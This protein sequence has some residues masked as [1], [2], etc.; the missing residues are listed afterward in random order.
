MSLVT[1]AYPAGFSPAIVQPARYLQATG[2][3]VDRRAD[4]Q[5]VLDLGGLVQLGPGVFWIGDQLEMRS[6]TTL[7]MDQSTTI[8]RIA[9]SPAAIMMLHLNKLH[10]VTIRGGCVDG[11]GGPEANG[12]DGNDERANC[13]GL[14]GGNNILIENVRVQNAPTSP[15]GGSY[16]DGLYFGS[17]GFN[18]ITNLLVI[19]LRSSSNGRH[20]S[21]FVAMTD[22]AFINCVWDNE[23]FFG[24]GEG[25]AIN[26]ESAYTEQ[27]FERLSF[28]GCQFS[29]TR[30]GITAVNH[31]GGRRQDI[32]FTACKF[33][34]NDLDGISAS[35]AQLSHGGGWTFR[36]CY[37]TEN[38][39][40]G[41]SLYQMVGVK[42]QGCTIR[43]NVSVGIGLGDCPDALVDGCLI[44][45]N[46]GDGINV[47][48]ATSE[49]DT[50]IIG[51]TVL[52]NGGGENSH[53][54]IA[55]SSEVISGGCR[56]T[57]ALCRIGNVTRYGDA[58]QEYGVF[59]RGVGA[60]GATLFGN[61]IFD[62]TVAD[63]YEWQVGD[64]GTLR[65]VSLL[66]TQYDGQRA[67]VLTRARAVAG[68][69]LTSTPGNVST[70]LCAGR[71]AIAAGA[72]S[73]TISLPFA[74]TAD[75]VHVTLRDADTTLTRIRAKVTADG[76][77]T[78]A[79]NATAT[80][81]VTFAWELV[82]H[83]AFNG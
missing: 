76:T 44:V 77:I 59:F 43:E 68:E 72:S 10:N 61:D 64:D 32:T 2:T 35:G 36:D 53:G 30:Y 17:D 19:G 38:G 28:Y 40:L 83:G 74:K 55:Q 25:G 79:G 4:L 75:D 21:Q 20:G 7:L 18:P 47:S 37:F 33:I 71:A 31:Y 24:L 3:T 27:V 26:L 56:L 12:F 34:N 60:R 65:S 51:C 67:A 29:N 8:K 41:L 49:I 50:T 69:D 78:V 42:V 66:G 52:N 9:G 54:I 45:A 1:V 63:I 39:G 73:M 57:I 81:T 82:K 46:G 22:S 13:I 70:E 14:E 16:G 15:L 5:A 11:N 6:N 80:A 58:T 23:G 62:N 48:G